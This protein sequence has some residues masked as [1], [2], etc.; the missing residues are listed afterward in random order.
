MDVIEIRIDEYGDD[1]MNNVDVLATQR[2][3]REKIE[4]ALKTTYPSA[5]I[6]IECVVNGRGCKAWFN[7]EEASIYDLET[8]KASEDAKEATNVEA[9]IYHI[10]ANISDWCVSSTCFS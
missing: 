9:I 6:N 8:T 4:T 3:F 5:S 10:S 1:E 7:G 2:V